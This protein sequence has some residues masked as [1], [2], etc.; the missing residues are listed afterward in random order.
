MDSLFASL[1]TTS[2]ADRSAILALAALLDAV[3]GDP[4][5]LWGRIWHPVVVI[6][7]ALSVLDR[8]L[9]CGPPGVRLVT[10]LVTVLVI[11]GGAAA[12]GWALSVWTAARPW[13]WV[14]EWLLVGIMIAQRDLFDHVRAVASG[15]SQGLPQGRAAVARIVGRDPDSLDRHGVARAAIESLFENFSDGVVAPMLWYLALGP[16]GLL[17]Y[18]AL[19]TCDS[20]IGHRSLTY[21]HFGRVAARADDVANL[22]PA[23]LAGLVVALAAVFVPGANPKAALVTLWRDA[24]KHRSP[25]AGW[26]EAAA[27]GALGLA[28]AGPRRYGLALVADPWIGTGRAQA[29]VVDIKRGLTLF[30]TSCLVFVAVVLAIGVLAGRG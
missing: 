9:N 28:L 22:I 6:G 27:A 3:L 7:R 15:L 12:L 20:M 23:R 26:P 1:G 24:S 29:E 21:L 16:A 19:N 8:G 11:V 4:R 18:K 17:G 2:V 14:A 13:G 10:G 25:N 30:A 5:W